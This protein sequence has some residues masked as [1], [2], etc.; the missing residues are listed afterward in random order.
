M[1]SINIEPQQRAY[2][3]QLAAG[4]FNVTFAVSEEGVYE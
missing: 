1:L 4:F 3:L 2:C